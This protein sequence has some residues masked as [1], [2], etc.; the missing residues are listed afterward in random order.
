[1]RNTIALPTTRVLVE[2]ATR[3]VVRSVTSGVAVELR[4][5]TETWA[6]RQVLVRPNEIAMRQVQH[7]DPE[8]GLCTSWEPDAD[9]I[10][11]AARGAI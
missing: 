3:V 4:P 8:H 5:G 9:L 2:L 7:D 10:Q 11:G 6:S 1:M